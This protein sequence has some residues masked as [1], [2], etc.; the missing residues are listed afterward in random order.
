MGWAAK[1]G[2]AKL[3]VLDQAMKE[4]VPDDVYGSA[5][6]LAEKRWKLTEPTAF[7]KSGQ[8]IG[9]DAAD[10]GTLAHTWIEAHLRGKD[11]DLAALP[12]P[13]RNAVESMLSWEKE[14]HLETI[15]TEETFY[16]CRLNYAGT[17]D[18]IGTLDGVLSVGDWKTSSGI[19]P[20]YVF[21]SWGYALADEASNDD[22]LYRQIFVG[23]FGKDGSSEVRI[24][25]RN[26]FPSSEIARD[27]LTA[28]GHIFAA[29]QE[30]ERLFPY[31]PKPKKEKPH[32]A[33]ATH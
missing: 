15:K 14:H 23:R 18:W 22:R 8:E 21:Q 24:F 26:E 5:R 32:E 10:Y 1:N 28:C 3:N 25:K 12:G 11:V 31:K 6:A 30:W 7:W 19:Y 16:N 33:T 2:V 29:L 27:V 9:K 13:S 17:A 4:L 20:N